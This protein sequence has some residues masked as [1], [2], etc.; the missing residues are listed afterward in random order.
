MSNDSPSVVSNAPDHADYKNGGKPIFNVVDANPLLGSTTLIQ[1][2]SACTRLLCNVLSEIELGPEEQV[3]YAL[4]KQIQR[5][6]GRRIEGQ[7]AYRQRK[8]GN[9]ANTSPD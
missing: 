4:M 9:S 2:N 6:H 1:L 7:K 8:F 5:N 3:I